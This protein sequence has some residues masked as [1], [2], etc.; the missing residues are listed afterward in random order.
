MTP[1]K[2]ANVT[3]RR[4]ML[5]VEDAEVKKHVQVE[6]PPYLELSDEEQESDKKK[7]AGVEISS[8]DYD[9]SGS[10]E[11][12]SAMKSPAVQSTPRK[13]VRFNNKRASYIEGNEYNEASEHANIKYPDE[14]M[15]KPPKPKLPILNKKKVKT[16]EKFADISIDL[17]SDDDESTKDKSESSVAKSASSESQK[18][19]SDFDITT[20]SQFNK[21]SKESQKGSG[22]RVEMN[23]NDFPQFQKRDEE[24]EELGE[25][26]SKNKYQTENVQLTVQEFNHIMIYSQSLKRRNVHSHSKNQENQKRSSLKRM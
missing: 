3:K 6:V 12:R 25:Y 13:S 16:V 9:L 4:K 1:K 22:K 19:L 20:S 26:E 14:E 23:I 17:H 21:R 15:M 10:N 5:D 18:G 8:S 24:K 11:K 7:I 2:D